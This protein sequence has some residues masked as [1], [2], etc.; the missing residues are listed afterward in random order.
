MRLRTRQR[1]PRHERPGAERR[2]IALQRDELHLR[3]T[4]SEDLREQD[5][6]VVEI[7]QAPAGQRLLERAVEQHEAEGLRRD[8]LGGLDIRPQERALPWRGDRVNEVLGQ[9]FAGLAVA[10]DERRQQG[11]T[12]LDVSQV[13]PFPQEIPQRL[14]IGRDDGPTGDRTVEA[15]GNVLRLRR[16]APHGHELRLGQPS[17]DLCEVAE[18]DA[19]RVDIESAMALE[20]ERA[21]EVAAHRDLRAGPVDDADPAEARI[22]VRQVVPDVVRRDEADVAAETDP[23]EDAAAEQHMRRRRAAGRVLPV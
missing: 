2:G 19:V 16:H 13:G 3:Q 7:A 20:Q 4:A 5:V 1:V 23:P 22:V 8:D 21:N 11:L 9:E 10:I 17:T 15:H 18:G 6:A 12:R 14:P